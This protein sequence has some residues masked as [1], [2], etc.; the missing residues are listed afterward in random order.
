MEKVMR[1]RFPV[2]FGCTLL[3]TVFC[4]SLMGVIAIWGPNPQPPPIASLFDTLKYGFSMGMFS[5]FGLLGVR[6]INP[7]S[8][9]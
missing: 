6:S 2:V 9:Q 4:G 3:L 7:P 1:D 8:Q 5:V